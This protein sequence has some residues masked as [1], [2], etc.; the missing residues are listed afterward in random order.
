MAVSKGQL[1]SPCLSGGVCS[2][3]NSECRS[4]VCRCLSQF[5]NR[6]NV[7]RTYSYCYN[8]NNNNNNNTVII[9]I[10]IQMTM[11]WC[12]HHDSV[13]ARVHI[14]VK[15]LWF[16]HML[17]ASNISKTAKIIKGDTIY[18]HIA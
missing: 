7:C 11:S 18:H 3:A 13:T 16:M 2:V 1:D 15:K 6:D 8:N 10:I 9:I 17:T 4:G 12:C 5:Y 14:N